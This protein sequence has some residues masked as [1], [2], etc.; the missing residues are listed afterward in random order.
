MKRRWESDI[1]KGREGDKRVTKNRQLTKNGGE[2]E[3]Q[4]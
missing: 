1:A 2:G 4:T 3:K